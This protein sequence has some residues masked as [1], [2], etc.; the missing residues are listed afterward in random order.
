MIEKMKKLEKVGKIH[1]KMDSWIQLKKP[2]TS[3]T[4]RRWSIFYEH[5]CVQFTLHTPGFISL[6]GDHV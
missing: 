6:R 5:K 2:I 1:I 3:I 4:T